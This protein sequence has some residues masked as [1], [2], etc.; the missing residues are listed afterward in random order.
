MRTRFSIELYGWMET[1][2]VYSAEE[3]LD[4]LNN[5]PHKF[6]NR[7]DVKI[8]YKDASITISTSGDD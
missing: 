7:K 6:L 1:D 3:L 8:S 5:E 2:K 4:S